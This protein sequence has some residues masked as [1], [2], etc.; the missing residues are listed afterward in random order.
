MQL[1]FTKLP[2]MGAYLIESESFTD[3]RGTFSRQFCK[4]TFQRHQIDFT[5]C[6]CNVSKH[7]Y[8]GVLRGL[9][10]QKTPYQEGKI[11]SCIAGAIFDVMVDLRPNSDTYLKWHSVE[12][13]GTNNRMV[14]IPPHFA[15]GFMSLQDDSCVMYQLDTYFMPEFYSGIR[16]DDPKIGIEWPETDR[17]IINDRDSSYADL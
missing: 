6:Q 11:V 1:K 3:A 7:N 2:L 9:H 15:H 13:T 12:L 16:W 8:K 17:R 14:Y 5:I 10:F 4:E